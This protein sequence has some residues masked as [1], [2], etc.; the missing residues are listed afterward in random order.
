MLREFIDDLDAVLRTAIQKKNL[1]Q[2]FG[3]E[4]HRIV[5]TF[6]SFYIIFINLF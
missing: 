2:V 5:K 6:F 1:Q 4:R 3:F